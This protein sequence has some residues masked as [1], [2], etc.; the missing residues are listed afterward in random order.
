M[1]GCHIPLWL[2][3]GIELPAV[4]TAPP[5]G[6]FPEQPA[7]LLTMEDVLD[8]WETHNYKTIAALK[9]GKHDD[10]LLEQS[11]NDAAQGFCSTPLTHAQLLR[12]TARGAI[13]AHSTLRYCAILRQE[14]NH[15][16]RGHRSI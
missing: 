14:E 10:V 7:H 2:G 12:G 13:S 3:S 4:G 5:Y 9:P 16:Q 11:L 15:R 1:G 8:D 6:V